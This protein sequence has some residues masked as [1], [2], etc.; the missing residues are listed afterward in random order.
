M[1]FKSVSLILAGTMLLSALPT[2]AAEDQ[3]QY[4]VRNDTRRPLT[5]GVRRQGSSAID[6]F[7]IRAG[8]SWT[9]SYS[10]SKARLILC[11]GTMSRWQ[12]MTPGQP[13]R[14]VA[15]GNDDRIVAQPVP[16]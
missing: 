1:M 6:S 14:L 9:G 4:S 3:G 11:E 13:Y 8:E 12:P 2:A 15:P 7:T 16:R 10:G 5:C